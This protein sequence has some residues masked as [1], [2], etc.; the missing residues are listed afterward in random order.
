MVGAKAARSC[1]PQAGQRAEATPAGSGSALHSP[2]PPRTPPMMAPIG[3]EEEPLD[4]PPSAPVAL[5]GPG[6]GRGEAG[7]LRA[8]GGG[9]GSAAGVVCRVWCAGVSEGSPLASWKPEQLHAVRRRT[10]TPGVPRCTWPH[11]KRFPSCTELKLSPPATG[12]GI[13]SYASE[14]LVPS[15]PSLLAPAENESTKGSALQAAA[16]QQQ[17]NV[18]PLRPRSHNWATARHKGG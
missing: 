3:T 7:G 4:V 11:A 12:E 18:C 8:A 13:G 5:L 15:S 16:L 17:G 9:E 14:E 10:H 1:A 6:G 2:A